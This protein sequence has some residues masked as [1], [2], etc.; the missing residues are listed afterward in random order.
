M[1]QPLALLQQLCVGVSLRASPMSDLAGISASPKPSL[2][3]L[4]T[5]LQVREGTFA[6]F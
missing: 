5:P 6:A 3:H 4:R 1:G 2:S